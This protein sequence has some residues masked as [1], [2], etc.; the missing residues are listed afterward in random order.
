MNKADPALSEAYWLSYASERAAEL[1]EA[2]RF[3][4]ALADRV[5]AQSEL[6]TRKAARPAVAITETDYCPL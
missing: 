3:A 5:A 4:L 6:L 2:G 1:I